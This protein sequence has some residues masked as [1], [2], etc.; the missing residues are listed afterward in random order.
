M[1]TPPPPSRNPSDPGGEP[2]KRSIGSGVGRAAA[3]A[4]LRAMRIALAHELIRAG[5]VLERRGMIVAA[6]GNLSAR[7]AV[8]R[9]LITRAGR[10]KGELGT[11]DFVEIPLA[12]AENA[13]ESREVSSEHRVHR[14]GYAAR[15]DAESILHA[16]PVALTAFAIR[17]YAP[18]FDRFDEGRLVV[19][20][21]AFVPY[22][23]S[24]TQALADA[25][26]RVVEGPEE[27]Q[28]LVLESHGALA[29]GRTVDEALSR[30]ET[31]EHLA[32]ILLAAERG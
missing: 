17:G 15:R 23:V 20:A 25:V 30:L 3:S 6:Q 28:L 24:G 9:M 22:H 16:H 29:L 19:G 32:A 5:R 21:T 10:R 14:A 1:T 27:P 4:R 18:D 7:V 12:S 2:P 26:R 11:R 31:A 8:D 13:P